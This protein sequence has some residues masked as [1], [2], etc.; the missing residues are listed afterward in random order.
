M[1]QRLSWEVNMSSDTQEDI[2]KCTV[3]NLIFDKTTDNREITR[4]RSRTY[5]DEDEDD[6]DN[7][8][9]NNIIRISLN[10]R[11]ILL[12]TIMISDTSIFFLYR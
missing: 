8:N 1:Q 4:N 6:I 10:D 11:K 5:D 7:D 2:L 3:I 12:M 9:N